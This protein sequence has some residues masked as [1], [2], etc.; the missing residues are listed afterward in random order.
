LTT[1][2]GLP[3]RQK[4]EMLTMIN[5]LPRKLHPFINEMKQIYTMDLIYQKCKPSFLHQYALSNLMKLG[6]PI[7]VASNSMR[8]T[9]EVMMQKSNLEQY[10]NFMLSNEDV[11]NAKPSPDIYI[12]AIN[13][14]LVL[15][16]EVLIVED[17]DNGIKAAIASGAHL[18]KVEGANE[19]T[20]DSILS[21]IANINKGQ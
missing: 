18:M 6:Y 14:L 2:D 13:K 11:E 21:R 15:P 5:G 10:M 19:V 16:E 17:N 4:L 20:L 8:N 7:A 3:T 9:V 1:F 12:K